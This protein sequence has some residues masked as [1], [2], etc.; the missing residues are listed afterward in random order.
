M[1]FRVFMLVVFV[2]V[3]DPLSSFA[4]EAEK[5]WR[6]AYLEG[7]SFYEFPKVLVGMAY[8]M[9]ERGL[10]KNSM[11][12]VLQTEK[13]SKEVWD[14]LSLNAEDNRV[15]FVA[16]AYYTGEW[17]VETFAARCAELQERIR[18]KKDIDAVLA[19][20]TW[21]GKGMTASKSPVPILVISANNPQASGIVNSVET[22]GKENVFATFVRDYSKRQLTLFHD[23]FS[24]KRLGIVYEDTS[25]GRSSVGLKEIEETADEI[26]FELVRCLCINSDTDQARESLLACHKKLADQN[27]DAV[28]VTVNNSVKQEMIPKLMQPFAKKGIPSYAQGGSLE[29]QGGVLLSIAMSDFDEQGKFS[30]N[31]LADI[32]LNG[33]KPE[34]IPQSYFSV[35]SLAINLRMA[36]MIGWNPSLEIL[37]AVD[38]IYTEMGK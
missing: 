22:S 27:V 4:G 2:F 37:A 35:V 7:G 10:I 23:I 19:F 9:K 11:L 14:W 3:I 13:T 5:V 24:F 15:E 25:N 36:T 34:E 16:D 21:A 28:F 1:L 32:I 12:G 26:G 8:G 31:A 20:G 33:K 30:G 29:V 38:E 18:T 6:L 17:N